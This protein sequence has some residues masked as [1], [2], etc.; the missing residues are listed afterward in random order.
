ME[1][2]F[3]EDK[4][5]SNIAKHGISLSEAYHFDLSKAV[6]RPDNRKDYAEQRYIAYG[7]KEGRLFAMVFTI[8]RQNIR[9]ISLRKANKREVKAYGK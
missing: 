4:N 6:V 7:Y 2:E 9:V 1:I 3:D 5:Q 8:R